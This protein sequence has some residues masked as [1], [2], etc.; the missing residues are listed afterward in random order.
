M[1]DICTVVFRDE[2]PILR[3]QA[4]S[5]GLYCK[6][7]GVRNI[8]VVLND[9]ETLASEIDPGWWGDMSSHVLVVPRTTFSAGWVENGWVSQQV[10]K[11]LCASL[12]YNVYTMVLDAKTIVTS[13]IE[14]NR[15]CDANGRIKV[16][17]LPVFE[18][19]AE[20]QRIAQELYSVTIDSQLG[21]GGV[22]YFFH[23]DTVRFLISDTTIRT[24]NSFPTWF[25]QQGMLTEYILYS[26]YMKFKYDSYDVFYNPECCFSIANL[27]H[28]QIA[29]AD[30]V[31]S[32]MPD[33]D[34]VGIHRGAWAKL[35]TE[36]KQQYRML[37][38]DRGISSAWDLA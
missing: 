5:V 28:S 4:Q 18:V 13:P 34:I 16:G 17:R 37:L 36:Q 2:L 3:L 1:I 29:Q 33:A 15:I 10:W 20:S 35:S 7:I 22:P 8:Y 14:L 26:A 38:I 12:S 32:R 31:L 19:F 9:A 24:R 21:P 27:C 25:Q 23:N 30:E 11:L 6:N